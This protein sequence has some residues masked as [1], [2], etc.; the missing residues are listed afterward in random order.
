MGKSVLELDN[1]Q[2]YNDFYKT[3]A[4]K[5]CS[6]YQDLKDIKIEIARKMLE[7]DKRTDLDGWISGKDLERYTEETVKKQPSGALKDLGIKRIHYRQF[8]YPFSKEIYSEAESIKFIFASGISFFRHCSSQIRLALENGAVVRVILASPGSQFVSEVREMQ[9]YNGNIDN[10]IDSEIQQVKSTLDL[11]KK[12]T[13]KGQ[14]YYGNFNTQFRANIMI[15]DDKI[16]YFTIV[17]PPKLSFESTSFDLIEGDLLKDCNLH[18]DTLFKILS[19][20]GQ[21]TQL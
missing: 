1:P 4:S 14:I 3:V 6:F 19:D 18:F 13:K 9:R 5:M 10:D 8:Q 15:I 11:L 16:G 17:L 7:Y 2:K 20:K 12:E 21:V